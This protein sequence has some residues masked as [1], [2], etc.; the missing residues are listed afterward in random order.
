M[1]VSQVR[2]RKH[3]EM[4]ICELEKEFL[5]YQKYNRLSAA[6]LERLKIEALQTELEEV[7]GH[8]SAERMGFCYE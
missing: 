1:T 2:T 3:I 8:E 5:F 6:R 7:S 4:E